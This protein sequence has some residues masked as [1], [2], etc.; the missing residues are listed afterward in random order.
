MELRTIRENVAAWHKAVN[1]T[2]GKSRCVAV[3]Y[4]KF[5]PV[6]KKREFLNGTKMMKML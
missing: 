6:E 2:K 4:V 1:D 3:L 5:Q